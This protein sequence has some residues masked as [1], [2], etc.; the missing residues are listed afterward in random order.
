MRF[1]FLLQQQQPER[2][3]F[4]LLLFRVVGPTLPKSS[5]PVWTPATTEAF[6]TYGEIDQGAISQ[7]V[8]APAGVFKEF[9]GLE[10]E[11]SSTQ[12]QQLT[13]AFLYLQN[14]P[15][16]CSEQ[17]ASRILS[18]AALRDVLHAFNSKGLPSQ[19][20]IEATVTR[21]IKRLEGM[22]NENGGFGFLETR[23]RVV[24]LS[25]YSRSSCARARTA[26]R[27]C[28]SGGDV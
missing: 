3:G 26:K 8:K 18:I 5:L 7:P 12:L 22:Q 15:Y 27:L 2:R 6:A 10:I 16:E 13:D 4:R 9:G 1:A 20:E 14:Y 17:L 19:A 11:A 28:G 24:A 25:E 23:R 21:D